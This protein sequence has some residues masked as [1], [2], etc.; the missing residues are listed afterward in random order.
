ME[1]LASV[2]FLYWSCKLW[3]LSTKAAC[4]SRKK[5]TG[6]EDCAAQGPLTELGWWTNELLGM[7]K[8]CLEVDLSNQRTEAK[9]QQCPEFVTRLLVVRVKA[10]W[11][12]WE[13]DFQWLVLDPPVTCFTWNCFW[14]CFLPVH[15]LASERNQQYC[16]KP[17]RG[18]ISSYS[19]RVF[20]SND[21]F[22]LRVRKE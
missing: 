20:S 16:N 13:R 18:L 4:P 21:S 12:F 19:S 1:V 9:P 2:G 17:E 15:L 14:T 6:E 22:V 7:N 10:S 3:L 11:N 5:E 8:G